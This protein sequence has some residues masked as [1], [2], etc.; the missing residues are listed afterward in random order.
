[1]QEYKDLPIASPGP[2]E[3]TGV[4][5]TAAESSSE[6]RV[7][8]TTAILPPVANQPLDIGLLLA[9]ST[10]SRRPGVNSDSFLGQTKIFGWIQGHR[11]IRFRACPLQRMYLTCLE[12]GDPE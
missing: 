1:M 10:P 11:C 7:M 8:D 3:D 5:K 4:Y 6:T 12:S 9:E 2:L